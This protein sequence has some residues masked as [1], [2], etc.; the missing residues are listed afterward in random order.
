MARRIPFLD[1]DGVLFLLP[2]VTTVGVRRFQ[3]LAVSNT[4]HRSDVA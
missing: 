2:S 4:E 3:Q 1:C